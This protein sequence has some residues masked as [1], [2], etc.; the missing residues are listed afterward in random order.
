MMSPVPTSRSVAGSGTVAGRIA[1]PLSGARNVSSGNVAR[2]NLNVNALPNAASR[3]PVKIV[4]SR[5][6]RKVGT[7]FSVNVLI[8]PP[9]VPPSKPQPFQPDQLNGQQ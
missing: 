5:N 2:A 3:S 1:M 8:S 9:G 6:D 4:P 7:V